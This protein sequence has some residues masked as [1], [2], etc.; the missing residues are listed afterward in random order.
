MEKMPAPNLE[1]IPFNTEDV[2]VTSGLRLDMPAS[3]I[4]YDIRYA[5]IGSEL[6]DAGVK[7]TIDNIPSNINNDEIY[8]FIMRENNGI[9]TVD[10]KWSGANNPT[11]AWYHANQWYTGSLAADA[12][13]QH[14]PPLTEF[15]SFYSN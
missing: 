2:I 4:N 1:V 3:P 12:S 11:Y 7:K 13:D 9:T 5:T 14:I 8:L 10:K 15:T 6:I